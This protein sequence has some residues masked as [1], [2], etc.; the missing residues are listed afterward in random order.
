[1]NRS[2][3]HWLVK[4]SVCMTLFIQQN[5]LAWKNSY[6][7]LS[8]WASNER[9]MRK[10]KCGILLF[11]NKLIRLWNQRFS[12]AEIHKNIKYAKSIESGCRLKM[13][14]ASRLSAREDDLGLRRQKLGLFG[15]AS[16]MKSSLREN[17]Q[18]AGWRNRSAQGLHWFCRWQHWTAIQHKQLWE[19]WRPTTL[20]C[21]YRRKYEVTICARSLFISMLY[22]PV[23][24]SCIH[25]P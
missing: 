21:Q 6:H 3:W 7:Y 23:V 1:M 5:H 10:T 15:L 9:P 8:N 2:Q 18:S 24:K 14:L 25:Q 11:I 17:A 19:A 12:A 4:K 13:F 22:C 16:S 20:S